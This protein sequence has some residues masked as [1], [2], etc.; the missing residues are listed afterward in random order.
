MN[1]MKLK[2]DFSGFNTWAREEPNMRL[3]DA[4]SNNTKFQYLGSRGAQ[5]IR[6]L[7]QLSSRRFNTW[8]REEPNAYNITC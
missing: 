8:A 5:L 3:A 7:I 2:Q 4:F 6:T 1:Y